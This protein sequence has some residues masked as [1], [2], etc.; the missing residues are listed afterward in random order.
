M[1]IEISFIIDIVDIY[2]KATVMCSKIYTL[3]IKV[4]ITPYPTIKS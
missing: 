1:A 3:Q 4:E 2:S